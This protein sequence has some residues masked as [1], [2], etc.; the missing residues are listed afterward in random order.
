MSQ[1]RSK[2]NNSK[3]NT[4]SDDLGNDWD[5]DWGNAEVVDVVDRDVEV[6]DD[7]MYEAIISSKQ[8]LTDEIHKLLQRNY[9]LRRENLRF[10]LSTKIDN[11]T[12]MLIEYANKDREKVPNFYK[13]F[14]EL[15]NPSVYPVFDA[16]F[17]VYEDSGKDSKTKLSKD[18]ESLNHTWTENNAHIRPFSDFL[19]A[20]EKYHTRRNAPGSVTMSATD[21]ESEDHQAFYDL[22]CPF[23]TPDETL[24]SELNSELNRKLNTLLHDKDAFVF[25]D[26]MDPEFGEK[27]MITV[28]RLLGPKHGYNG[29]KVLMTGVFVLNKDKEGKKSDHYATLDLRTYMENVD[30]LKEG[31]KALIY[32]HDYIS[33]ISHDGDVR[34][35]PCTIKK[36]SPSFLELALTNKKGEST[37]LFYNKANLRQNRFMIFS[38]KVKDPM[39]KYKTQK[40]NTFVLFNPNHDIFDQ[41][42][43]VNGSPSTL[44]F[45]AFKNIKKLSALDVEKLM[46]QINYDQEALSPL[47]QH[48]FRLIRENLRKTPKGPLI[49]AFQ[50]KKNPAAK[51]TPPI[52][53][54]VNHTYLNKFLDSPLFRTHY[55][56]QKYD[57]GLLEILES[58]RQYLESVL[59][60]PSSSFYSQMNNVA[61][62][63]RE[64]TKQALV[65]K[66]ADLKKE[67]EKKSKKENAVTVFNS[68]PDLFAENERLH[69]SLNTDNVKEIGVV[70]DAYKNPVYVK[71]TVFTENTVR[72][73]QWILEDD[74]AHTE[75]FVNDHLLFMPDS[76]E[77]QKQV[78]KAQQDSL[79][80]KEGVVSR[81]RF[82]REEIAHMI[83][84]R[85]AISF[86]YNPEHFQI[87]LSHLKKNFTGKEL[88]K[89]EQ[90]LQIGEDYN[91]T[92][93]ELPEQNVPTLDDDENEGTTDEEAFNVARNTILF[94]EKVVKNIARAFR[95]SLESED[96][97]WITKITVDEYDESRLLKD[98]EAKTQD[99]IKFEARVRRAGKDMRLYE[100]NLNATRERNSK[101]HQQRMIMN[102]RNTLTMISAL[103]SLVV[104][105]HRPKNIML[106]MDPVCARDVKGLNRDD[107]GYFVRYFACY[108]KILSRNI[109][110]S[111]GYDN[112]FFPYLEALGE[113]GL[114]TREQIAD[115]ILNQTT[116]ALRNR[117]I[118]EALER[119]NVRV[120]REQNKHHKFVSTI[121]G[122]FR[123]FLRDMIHKLETSEQKL[124]VINVK[125]YEELVVDYVMLLQNYTRQQEITKKTENL[126]KFAHD[127]T[128][129]C[130]E[131]I[132]QYGTFVNLDPQ[133]LAYIKFHDP[134]TKISSLPRLVRK[135]II[136]SESRDPFAIHPFWGVNMDFTDGGRQIRRPNIKTYL[137]FPTIREEDRFGL[138]NR[139]FEVNSILKLDAFAFEHMNT[140][141]KDPIGMLSML[142]V[143][144]AKAYDNM[145]QFLEMAFPTN[146]L[147]RDGRGLLERWQNMS[148]EMQLVQN[149]HVLF[150]DFI[151]HFVRDLL[152]VINREVSNFRLSESAFQKKRAF[153]PTG[154]P[155]RL[156]E[157]A[158]TDMREMEMKKAQFS[159]KLV[160]AALQK[161]S[162]FDLN[163]LIFPAHRHIEAL[164][165]NHT[166]MLYVFITVLKVIFHSIIALD[167]Q[168]TVQG[169]SDFFNALPEMVT[170]NEN[171]K[172]GMADVLRNIF[173]LY[174]R[175]K[176]LTMV[177]HDHLT[178][179][180]KKSNDNLKK[181]RTKRIERNTKDEQQFLAYVR[182]I[183]LNEVIEDEN[184]MLETDLLEEI[185]INESMLEEGS[186]HYRRD[187]T[188]DVLYGDYEDHE[189]AYD[190]PNP[191]EEDPDPFDD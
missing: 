92:Y 83:I 126:Y 107:I 111:L 184:E 121:D 16:K 133:Q 28:R 102:R 5:N 177:L 160:D 156:F 26:V 104:L 27:K 152:T 151:Y 60:K 13:N 182:S 174:E 161:V 45:N 135:K 181:K 20:Y 150:F 137:T 84:M 51:N 54:G 17:F 3:R 98:Y 185:E 67:K 64:R 90:L 41:V 9:D 95:V 88:A 190:I 130:Y 66:I 163:L 86:S 112:A 6:Y 81:L 138:I 103:L 32:P 131:L 72:Y 36:V 4:N 172:N 85:Q 139:F 74:I 180:F 108:L 119:S 68:F 158:E 35:K 43:F 61:H 94:I 164:L 136:A 63:K 14:I 154:T 87:D 143:Y 71:K 162:V 89:E 40:Q 140:P 170:L 124:N 93:S 52:L 59:N 187:E 155:A 168:S 33:L 58:T 69:L 23:T 183:G 100:K 188:D 55:L 141:E 46:A 96:I 42:A 47:S 109:H 12:G 134:L 159:Q 31:D 125:K 147:K 105:I 75:R 48:I 175:R 117:I 144:V 79:T 82:I 99:L 22:F 18:A 123:P 50:P 25:L 173:E 78:A 62:Q 34:P 114:K 146:R 116:L 165:E 97:K 113:T 132:S 39:T 189:E 21:L 65:E 2:N 56:L 127:P 157:I 1:T 120:A 8:T 101:E 38:P 70:L 15:K 11:I 77:N 118:R 91:S 122:Q 171:Q 7:T 110:E 169:N 10:W 145:Q 24:A 179:E 30:D 176:S 186:P 153:L 128:A 76:F 167:M 49:R 53:K 73:V 19:K 80:Y 106:A 191:Y 29:D 129:C 148:L 178:D 44:L 149:D 115:A 166:L 37:E 142:K 57:G